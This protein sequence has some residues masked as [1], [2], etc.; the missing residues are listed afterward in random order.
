MDRRVVT[1]PDDLIDYRG[2]IGRLIARL[3]D[4]EREH[5]SAAIIYFDAGFNNVVPRIEKTVRRS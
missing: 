2:P 5:G 1:A 3:Q 4:L